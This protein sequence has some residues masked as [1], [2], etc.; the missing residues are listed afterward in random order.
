MKKVIA[1][2]CLSM[3]F[4]AACQKDN[5]TSHLRLQVEN[6]RPHGKV[7]VGDGNY[8]WFNLGDQIRVNGY[9]FRMAAPKSSSP[10]PVYNVD[11]DEDML[12]RQPNYYD[13]F[14]PGVGS[15][16][17]ATNRIYTLELNATQP[18]VE[19][20]DGNQKIACVMAGSAEVSDES[21]TIQMHNLTALLRVTINPP[22][23][24][25]T[26]YLK[27]ITVRAKDNNGNERYFSGKYTV[28]M[29]A[30]TLKMVQDVSATP[31]EGSQQ[32]VLAVPEEDG[33]IAAGGS[34]SFYVAVPPMEN[35]VKFTVM[36]YG[37]LVDNAGKT[38]KV[39]ATVRHKNFT[40]LLA[41]EIGPIVF[42]S[43][44]EGEGQLPYLYTVAADAQGNPTKKVRFSIGNLQYKRGG[45]HSRLVLGSDV[46]GTW[47]FAENQYDYIGANNSKISQLYDNT[48]KTDWIDLFG[49]AT[50]QMKWFRARFQPYEYSGSHNEYG[51]NGS[52]PNGMERQYDWGA[53]EISNGGGVAAM[54]SQKWYTMPGSEWNYVVSGSS[55]G[56]TVTSLS[57]TNARYNCASL[58]TVCGVKGVILLPDY[59]WAK[60]WNKYVNPISCAP[61]VPNAWNNFNANVY[62][63]D[64]WDEMEAAGAVFIP[65][66]GKRV[67]TTVTGYSNATTGSGLVFYWTSST[68]QQSGGNATSM[69]VY[70]PNATT[71]IL[72]VPDTSQNRQEGASVRLVYEVPS[73]QW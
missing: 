18:Y 40:D 39:I 29:S 72:G 34:K 63:Q 70:D 1:M 45:T 56:G 66:G 58:A 25:G 68:P 15:S 21:T 46:E 51:T 64:Q 19:D 67:G 57:S 71:P 9:T 33:M 5:G 2:L 73:S 24:G 54:N 22:A 14:Y 48:N 26:Y 42:N 23:G 47:R 27:S 69:F 32:M 38:S 3:L 16:Y 53:N 7:Y 60:N 50:S 65:A 30:S 20:G 41:S 13:I 17:D 4:F 62:N 31:V 10:N 28:D 35:N 52:A 44:S 8:A 36:I 43:V 59:S 6:P 12:N 55:A 61:F 11:V 49:W 37:K